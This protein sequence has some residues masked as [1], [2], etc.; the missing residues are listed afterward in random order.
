MFLVIYLLVLNCNLLFAGSATLTWDPVT[1][2]DL[3][4]YK[5]YRTDDDQK[6][7]LIATT[8]K[9]TSF[10]DKTI[11]DTVTKVT[12][13]LTSFDLTGN[14]SVQS[15]PASKIMSVTPSIPLKV[16]GD[17]VDF[18][19]LTIKD[20]EAIV[21]FT[22]VDDG[23]GNPANVDIRVGSPYISWGLSTSVTFGTCKSPVVGVKVGQKR[24][25]TIQGL[26]PSS[27]NGIQ[28][29]PFA[30]QMN[31]P[32]VRYGSLINPIKFSTLSE[33]EIFTNITQKDNSIT[34]NYSAKMCPRGVSRAS[35]STRTDTRSITLT[36]LK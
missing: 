6:Q 11:P 34:M 32:T 9:V 10:E 16:V 26:K 12:Y 14:E 2:K 22:E 30:G 19:L 1:D 8:G 23:T 31:T 29:V 35:G 3:A 24:T 21:E 7:K 4:G 5:V 36:C 28:A 20:T 33:L 25:C 13:N 18:K 17:L 27:D 15:L